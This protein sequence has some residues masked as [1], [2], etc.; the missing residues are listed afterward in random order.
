MQWFQ[1]RWHFTQNVSLLERLYTQASIRK[2]P[3][4]ELSLSAQDGGDMWVDSKVINGLRAW[5]AE[6]SGGIWAMGSVVDQFVWTY[7]L[8]MVSGY[9]IFE[10][11][12]W[13]FKAI[14]ATEGWLKDA[15]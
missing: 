14:T 10:R 13:L 9:G 8:F 2:R 12:E 1:R 3:Y 6:M 5:A 7:A 4:D 15:M 11:C